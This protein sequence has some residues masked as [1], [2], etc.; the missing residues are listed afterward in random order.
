M[1]K[2]QRNNKAIEFQM[3]RCVC[4]VHQARIPDG[5]ARL[6]PVETTPDRV[7]D[8]VGEEGGL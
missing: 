6:P 5:H 8:G 2:M 7:Q 1:L 4:G 3:S